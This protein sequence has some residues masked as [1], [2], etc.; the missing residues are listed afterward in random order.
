MWKLVL[1]NQFHDAL[2]G[3]SI[4]ECYEDSKQH[5]HQVAMEGSALI[6]DA[7]Q[8]LAGQDTK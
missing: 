8:S 4:A 1:L 5:Y 7:V 3:S 6:Q 2:P